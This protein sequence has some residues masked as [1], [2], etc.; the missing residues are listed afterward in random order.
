MTTYATL[1]EMKGFLRIPSGDTVDD[2]ELGYALE[3]ASRAVDHVCGQAFPVAEESPAE[4]T[5]VVASPRWLRSLGRYVV[6]VP[7]I[8]VGEVGADGI[9]VFEWNHTDGDWT[10]QYADADVTAGLR[11]YDPIEGYPAVTSIVLPAGTTFD[12]GPD[13]D[14]R[15]LTVLVTA[16]FGWPEVP[17]TVKAATLIQASRFNKRRDAV[18][19]VVGAPDG[20]GATRLLNRVDPDVELMLRPYTLIW[21][22]R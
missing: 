17:G 18:F 5:S 14:E 12:T 10:E 7:G 15:G 21:A 20:S 2:D 19:G 1:A 4:R 16:Y 13:Y 3:A 9:E 22:A 8:A 6:D 11:P